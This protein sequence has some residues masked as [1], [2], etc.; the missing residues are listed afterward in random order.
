MKDVFDKRDPLF[1]P[2]C[3]TFEPTMRMQNVAG[4]NIIPGED[5]FCMDCRI[6][7]CYTL[8]EVYAEVDKRCKAIEKKYGVKIEYTM[9]QAGESPATPVDAPVVQKLSEALKAVHGKTA[10][11]IGI[12]GGTVAA[13]LRE[14][15]YNAAVWI[16]HPRQYRFRRTDARIFVRRLN[17]TQFLQRRS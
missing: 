9:P 14:L 13:P 15:G 7:P 3:S 5:V 6:I 10:R 1:T 11:T 12:G 2:D 16:L 8:K 17:G 4:I